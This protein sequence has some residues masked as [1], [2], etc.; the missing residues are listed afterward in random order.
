LWRSDKEV[1]LIRIWFA[2]FWSDFDVRDNIFDSVLKEAGIAFRLSSWFPDL[3][4][5]S[6][7]GSQHKRYRCKKVFY[8][9]ENVR[10][11]F[12]EC[13]YAISF[14]YL[15]DV[16]HLRLPGYIYHAWSQ[17]RLMG[18]KDGLSAIRSMLLKDRDDEKIL[19]RKQ[20]FC[21]F[22]VGNGSVERRNEFFY[23]LSKYRQVDSAGTW[24]NN[25]G[26]V[27]RSVVKVQF[28]KDYKF[29]IAFENSSSPGYTTEKILD[30]L[31][32]NC[33][34]I[35]WGDPMVALDFSE[36]CFVNVGKFES[37][38]AAIQTI[39]EL[40]RSDDM[41]RQYLA[42]PCFPGNAPPPYWELQ[43]LRDFLQTAMEQ[44]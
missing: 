27:V 36:R 40:D 22:I 28:L 17:A 29:N 25:T 15:E 13:D 20:K 10:P 32:A 14:D 24:L 12:S 23:K 7:F 6:C 21:A 9:G 43:R 37:D 8:T 35:Y 2:D 41:Y 39:I 33:V 5:Y 16:R 26:Q 31:L 30:A 42:A 11:N 18:L 4:I 34:P 19:A 1:Q 44:A 38:E 3:L